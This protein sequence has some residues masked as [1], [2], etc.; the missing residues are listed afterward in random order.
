MKKL[1]LASALVAMLMATSANADTFTL[2]LNVDSIDNTTVVNE[3]FSLGEVD[4]V[5]SISLD[6]AHTWGGDLQITLTA[7][8]G[9]TYVPV[10]APT[11]QTGS[12]NF[13]LGVVAG[14]SSLANVA[15]YTFVESGGL[16]VFDD[17]SGVAPSGIYDAFAWGPGNHAAGVW[18][19][20]IDDTV[21]GDP[22]SV[23]NFVIDFNT[24][25]IPEPTTFAVLVGL[26]GLAVSR[27]RR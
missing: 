19:L 21:G 26:T 25:A 13:D 18:N 22:T 4:S 27:R 8:D 24:S 5:K 10:F 20:L 9:S 14:D 2:P 1:F 6:L 16:T 17:T 15:T 23:G 11:D 7:P 12:G 3:S